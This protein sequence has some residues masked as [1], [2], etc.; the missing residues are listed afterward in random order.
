MSLLTGPKTPAYK[1]FT[2]PQF[3]DYWKIQQKIHW[4]AEEI[5]MT[6]DVKD[7]HTKLTEDEKRLLTSLF[8]FFVQA[9]VEVNDAYCQ[10]YINR[11][12][13]IEVA[14]FLRAASNSETTHIDAYSHLIE[15]LGM[16]EDTYSVFMDYKEMRDKH[17]FN[18]MQ[19]S[20]TIH[21]LVRTMAI[22]GAFTEGLQLFASF[23]ILL[24]FPRFNKMKGMGQI[25]SYSVRDE[26]LHCGAVIELMHLV[27]SENPK[28]W[29][30]QLRNEILEAYHTII[31]HEDAFID[32]AFKGITIKGI[33]AEQTK[34]YIRYIGDRRLIQLRLEPVFHVKENPFPWMDDMLNSVEYANFFEQRPTEYS[35]SAL[36]GAWDDEA[37]DFS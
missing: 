1:P 34:R 25:I 22:F 37:F 15:T 29:T 23:A 31:K 4:L 30:Q 14:M 6:A 20:E 36:T 11:F 9:D 2:Y 3:Y 16:P 19:K 21:E 33:D 32:L 7:W 13:H 18:I 27:V 8:R 10:H 5:P 12:K 28:I 35:K 17:E 26:S 24:N